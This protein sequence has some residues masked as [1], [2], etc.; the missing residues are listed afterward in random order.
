YAD[1]G[2]EIGGPILKDR[3]WGWGSAARTNVTTLTLDGTPDKTTLTDLGLKTNAQ[4]TSKLRGSFTFFS[5][6]KQKDGRGAGP[7]NPPET[8][9][10][11]DGPSK[12]YKGEVDYTASNTL[13]MAVRFAHV[14]GPFSLEPKGGLD[15]QVFVDADGVFHNTNQYYVTN[16]PQKT[17]IGEGNWFRGR[18]EVKFGGTYRR[19]NDTTQAGYGNGWLDLEQDADSGVTIAVPFRPYVQNLQGNY[20]ALYVGDTMSLNRL[21]LNG[22]LRYDR[23]TD[24]VLPASVP[25]HPDLPSVLPAVQAPGV[26]NAVVWNTVSPRAGMTYSLGGDRKTQLRASYAAFASQLNVTTANAVSAAGYA[27]AYYLAVDANHNMNIEPNEL[28]RQLAVVGVNPDNPL[29]VVNQID[30]H[31]KSPR[32]H[33]IVAGVDHELMPNFGLSASYTWRRFN[34]EIWP[35][36]QLP[37]VGVTSADYVLDGQ[38]GATL[39]DGSSVTAPY[40]ALQASAAPVGGGSITENRAG[41][42]RTFKGLEFSATKRL[43]NRWMGRFAY[44]W[45]DER[46]FFDNPAT[47][48]VDPTSTSGDPHIDGGNVVRA[49][50]GSGKSQIYLTAPRYQIVANGF[51]QGP[52]GIDLGANFLVRQG[53]AEVFYAG[54][55]ATNDAVHTKKN[56]LVGDNIGAYRLP[57]LHQLDVRAEKAFVLGSVHAAF[58][59]D[60]FNALNSGTVLGRQYDVQSSNFNAITEIMNPRIV[61]FGLR[62]NF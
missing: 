26:K 60:V 45:N 57:T 24:S 56:V 44:S 61:R 3:W 22:A 15:K 10:V 42:H 17:V 28:V 30:P 48:I 52:W 7:L 47:S 46:E 11:Q 33:E 8:T 59:V 13:F 35:L 37:V 53:F 39:P 58:D 4:L 29:Q 1:Y 51:Y 23:A 34:N 21:T 5:G 6:N 2:T 40:Y 43:A 18:H 31:L 9:F 19:V 62:F 16:R 12:L 32:T 55:V 36:T 20:S 38:I 54:N 50:A 27:Y 41:Y 49:T 25:A 14:N